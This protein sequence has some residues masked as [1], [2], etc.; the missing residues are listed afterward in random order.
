METESAG[1]HEPVLTADWDPRSE[2]VLSDQI[3]AFDQMRS[4]CPV[5]RSQYGYASVFRHG[6]VLRVLLDHETFSSAVS[7]FPS[8]PNGMDPPE[9][10]EFRRIIDPYF[11]PARVAEF[12]PHCR[13]IA[14][15]LVAMMPNDAEVD[16]MED[17]AQVFALQVQCAFLGWPSS[18]H[19]PLRQWTRKNHHATL[20]RD[21]AAMG[22]VAMEFDGYIKDLLAIRRAA[23]NNAPDDATTRLLRETVHGRLLT[24]EEIVSILRNWT[25][26]ELATISASVGI[27]THYLATHETLQQTLRRQPALLPAAIDEVLR[28]HPPLIMNR[29]IATRDADIGGTLIA[30]GERLALL[31]ASANRDEKVFG[32]PDEFRLDRDPALNLLYGAGIHV[33]PGAPLARVE[34]RIVLEELLTSTRIIAL[35]KRQAPVKAFYPGSGYS[36]LP[37]AIKR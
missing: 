26:G 6:D 12:E 28:I 31:W 22:A 27:L 16:W 13:R 20:A 33:C 15:D 29:R 36:Q 9:H 24:E 34:L 32:D 4:R 25:V 37:I 35:G 21:D 8:V 30:Q 2:A 3:A 18:L 14:S 19:E 11:S 5:A 1:P 10:T 7:R 23:G 17:F